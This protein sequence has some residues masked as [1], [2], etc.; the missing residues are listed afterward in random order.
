[1]QGEFRD[2]YWLEISWY[3]TYDI[4]AMNA[5]YYD[6]VAIF[7]V[8]EWRNPVRWGAEKHAWWKLPPLWLPIDL[9]AFFKQGKGTMVLHRVHSTVSLITIA[10]FARLEWGDDSW[11]GNELAVH[12][13]QIAYL[14]CVLHITGSK[15]LVCMSSLLH[16]RSLS[17]V[18]SEHW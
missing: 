13:F 11:D 6:T 15:F 16:V 3:R 9:M 4:G 12:I 18:L 17:K 8:F 2:S 14:M 5:A 1:M 10:T 7:V